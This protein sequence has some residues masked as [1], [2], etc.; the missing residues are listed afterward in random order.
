MMHLCCFTGFTGKA[1]RDLSGKW[2][3]HDKSPDM[4]E[5]SSS[6]PVGQGLGY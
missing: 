4:L 2:C 6:V 1:P 3:F 5:I